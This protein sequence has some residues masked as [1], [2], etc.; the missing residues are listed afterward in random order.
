MALVYI[1]VCLIAY[2]LGS[3]SFSVIFSKRFAGFDVRDKGSHNAGTTN[4]LRT[5][6]KGAAILTLLCD[7]LKGAA[8]VLVAFIASKIWDDINGL[9]LMYLAGLFA[10]IGH[11]FPIFFEFR[12]GKGVATALGVLL[13][14]NVKIGLICLIFALIIIA[15]TRTVS[16]GSILAAILFPILLIFMDGDKTFLSILIGFLIA[17][18]VIY[19]HRENIKR[20][21]DGK[22]KLLFGKWRKDALGFQIVTKRIRGHHIIWACF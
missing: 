14:L 10:I 22:E 17:A 11:T 6:G 15:I 16:I 21:R 5:V 19:N 7:A 20:I 3:I 18:F 2:L 13:A 12:G 1:I 4:V 9:A 8:A